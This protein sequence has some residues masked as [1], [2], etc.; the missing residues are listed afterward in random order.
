MAGSGPWGA[1]AA[2]LLAGCGAQTPPPRVGLE[3]P[4]VIAASTR[5][6]PVGAD[7]VIGRTASQLEA[8]SQQIETLYALTARVSRLSL[9]DFL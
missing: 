8:T 5:R 3:P 6:V 4:R 7:A 2:L 1:C 9:V